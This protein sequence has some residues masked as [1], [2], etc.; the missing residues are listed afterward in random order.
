MLHQ[1]SSRIIDQSNRTAV[2]NAE[3]HLYISNCI[4]SCENIKVQRPSF[5]GIGSHVCPLPAF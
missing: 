4:S 1:G 3:V 2:E 5:Q